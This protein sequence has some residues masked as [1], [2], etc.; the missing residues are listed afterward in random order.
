MNCVYCG[1]PLNEDEAEQNAFCSWTCQKKH[2]Y[3]EEV[4]K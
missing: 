4:K 1:I 2:F 3:Y